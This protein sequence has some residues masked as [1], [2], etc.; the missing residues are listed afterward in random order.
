MKTLNTVTC[1]VMAEPDRVPGE[2]N[3]FAWGEDPGAREQ[4]TALPGE[5]GPPT[6]R[7]P[8]LGG[9]RAARA[10]ERWLLPPRVGLFR[11]FGHGEF[12]RE[13]RRSR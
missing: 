5:L 2:H 11:S 7:V 1:R 3:V 9:N 6:G 4:V 13:V 12:N 8:D 10:V